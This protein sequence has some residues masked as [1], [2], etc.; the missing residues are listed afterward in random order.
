MTEQKDYKKELKKIKHFFNN[1]WKKTKKI[2]L[3]NKFKKIFAY[4]ILIVSLIAFLKETVLMLLVVFDQTHFA[5][6]I[7]YFSHIYIFDYINQ[8]NFKYLIIS[9]YLMDISVWIALIY[10]SFK[11]LN[12]KIAKKLRP[13]NILLTLL[14]FFI[15]GT[16][17]FS[18]IF[19]KSMPN[20]LIPF[21]EI[22]YRKHQHHHKEHKY[23][24][25]ETSHGWDIK[26]EKIPGGYITTGIYNNKDNQNVYS[27]FKIENRKLTPEESSKELQRI[28]EEQR[29]LKREMNIRINMMEEEFNRIFY[30]NI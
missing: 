27:K 13:K 29:Q 1:I 3:N 10:W 26:T 28:I 7:K 22:N 8:N 4:I 2:I 14:S 16:V 17:I 12:K 6:I 24:N 23:H 19:W 9:G 20:I 11:L 5:E 30:R 18:V 25:N 15:T 21:Q